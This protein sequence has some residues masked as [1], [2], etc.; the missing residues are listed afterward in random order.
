[1]FI[2]DFAIKRP[3]VTVVSMVALV[4]FGVV[5]A[6]PA[7]DRRVPGRAA[8]DRRTWPSPIPG[9]SPDVVEREVVEPRRG[10]DLRHQRRGPHQR[11]RAG[12][13][14]DVIVF[15]VF[16]KDLQQATQDIRDEISAIR[17]DLPPEMKEP[18]LTRFDPADMPIVSL[19]AD[20]A[21]RSTRRADA[22]R[23]SGHHAASCAA[24][25]ASPRSRWSAASSAS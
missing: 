24:S 11:Q 6:R 25:P 21:R 23:R 22:D 8:A 12:R 9:A 10:G 17:N 19:V 15:F 7:A 14:R 16:E 1:M 5:L 13:L 20:L 2:S 3:I 18:I 4:V